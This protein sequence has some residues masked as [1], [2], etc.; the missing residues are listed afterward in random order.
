MKSSSSEYSFKWSGGG[1]VSQV[2]ASLTSK[3]PLMVC[4]QF[5][6]KY[7]IELKL[8]IGEN[9]IQIHSV[10]SHKSTDQLRWL[11]KMKK[12]SE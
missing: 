4:Q 12:I 6:V 2:T 10:K 1:Y 5:C 9:G 8:L 11:L 7:R 3:C